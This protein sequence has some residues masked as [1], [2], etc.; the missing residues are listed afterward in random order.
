MGVSFYDQHAL[1]YVKA[2]ADI[3]MSELYQPFLQQIP[4]GGDI[5]DAGCGSGRDAKAF[6]ESGYQVTAMDASAAMVQ[7][8]SRLLGQATLHLSFQDM[9]FINMFD[10]IWACASLLHVPLGELDDVL[11]RLANALKEGGWLYASFKV[12]AGERKEGDRLFTYQTETSLRTILDSHPNLQIRQ[13][14]QS[15]DRKSGSSQERWLNALIRKSKI[16]LQEN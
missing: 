13:L 3:D 6:L 7:L 14:W 1:E 5:L 11:N 4:Q 10:G 16:I 15:V 9:T 12:G 8:S 2:T